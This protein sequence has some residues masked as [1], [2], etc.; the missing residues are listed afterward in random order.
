MT[1]P[2]KWRAPSEDSD[3]LGTQRFFMRTVKTPVRLD[4]CPCWSKSSL[5][6]QV[7]LLFLSCSGS[8]SNLTCEISMLSPVLQPC[9]AN[10]AICKICNKD[11]HLKDSSGD[12]TS[13]LMECGICWEIVH[14]NCLK[15]KENLEGEGMV[16]ED[17]PNS[18]ICLKCHTDGKERHLKVG[19]PA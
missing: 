11:T 10:S 2:T 4:R 16:N 17:L 5:G 7:I 12:E 1:N 18:W 14:P 6:A 13:T 3:Q 9:L 8:V 19:I 15:G